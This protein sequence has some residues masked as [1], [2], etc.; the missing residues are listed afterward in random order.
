MTRR[1]LVSYLTVTLFVLLVLEIP[2]GIFFAERE[3]ERLVANVERDAVVLATIYEDA[4]DQGATYSL[5]PAIDYA[6]DTGTR[7]VLVNESGTSLIDTSAPAYQDFTNR[8]EI[9]EALAGRRASGTRPSVTLGE[10][11]LY[12]AVP[13]ASGGVVHGAVRITYPTS[14]VDA[15]IA[16]FRWTLAAVAAVVLAAIAAVGTVAAR[17]VVEPIRK[18]DRAA[19]EAAATGDLTTRIDPGDAPGELRRL[20]DGFNEMAARLEELIDRHRRFVADASH[21]LRT[22]LTALRLRLENLAEGVE[23]RDRAG[24]EAAI[25]E[26]NRLGELV[27]QLLHLARLDGRDLPIETVDLAALVRE[28]ADVWEAL[29]T[30]QEADVRVD[31][32][33]RPV[34]ASAVHGGVEQVLDNYLSNALKVTPRGGMVRITV[35]SGDRF[36]EVHVLDE[37]PGMDPSAA[38]AAFERFWTTDRER[39]GSGLGLAIVAVLAEAS[40]GTAEL[41]PRATGGMDAVIRLPAAGSAGD[42][43]PE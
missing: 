35:A 10:D 7:V 39:G 19:R 25:E 34:P 5:Q 3:R 31:A 24:I 15:R 17:S 20:V 1:L 6:E 11:L 13:V 37:G 14:Q 28:R 38:A 18:V 33:E 16:R 30:E 22:P 41:V 8:P 23:P 4:L 36:Q 9:T 12:V 40:G 29:A 27:D 21:Q 2:L 26:T 43:L 32:P 42:E